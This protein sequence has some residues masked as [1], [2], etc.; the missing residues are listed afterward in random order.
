MR[1]INVNTFQFEEFNGIAVPEYG[2]LSHTWEGEEV[3]YVEMLNATPKTVLTTEKFFKIRECARLAAEVDLLDYIWVDTCCIDK[4][5]SAELQEAINSMYRW[6]QNAQ[7]CYVYLKDVKS[8]ENGSLDVDAFTTCR[9][10]SR[11]WTLQELIAPSRVEFY[12]STWVRIGS[13]E[14]L[15]E[16]ISS[17]S[18]I[19][20]TILLT[21][22]V[23]KASVAQRMSWAASRNCTRLEDTAYSL[24]GLF[25]IHMP[26][27]YGEGEKAFMRLQEEII[28]TNFDMS[29]FAWF[30][31]ETTS[32][33]SGMLAKSPKMFRHCSRI[34]KQVS[35]GLN[36]PYS[37]TNLGLYMS[38]LLKP[39]GIDP[40]WDVYAGR[41]TDISDENGLVISI[42]LKRV[43]PQSN[44]FVR[45]F[46]SLLGHWLEIRRDADAF[47]TGFFAY[48][49]FPITKE[50]P[51]SNIIVVRVQSLTGCF[52]FDDGT[53]SAPFKCTIAR[54][55]P[56]ELWE[57]GRNT[58]HVYRHSEDRISYAAIWIALPDYQVQRS[59]DKLSY[60]R[61][62]PRQLVI[63]LALDKWTGQR[64]IHLFNYLFNGVESKN[65]STVIGEIMGKRAPLVV[66][67]GD[68]DDLDFLGVHEI[69][70]SIYPEI[71]L[72]QFVLDVSLEM[73]GFCPQSPVSTP[74]HEKGG[75]QG[76]GMDID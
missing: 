74:L 66:D 31:K 39:M 53:A 67:Q 44:Q 51:P 61:P 56:G 40:E 35:A 33:Y 6:Y 4:S 5:S 36:T 34:V 59:N 16:E 69:R 63:T 27:L 55:W 22:D 23:S 65:M 30:D 75:S 76:T 26:M 8:I 72:D 48:V 14:E 25:D 46:P 21:G 62:R 7:W 29:I 45:A 3:Q 17:A 57:P 28:K 58:F 71:V 54:V 47:Q 38:I 18:G 73:S 68:R 49:N 70:A 42:F 60:I 9:W 24:M 12:S 10:I 50:H 41:L 52:M 13:K 2:I 43:S 20:K 64:R 32:S 1:L 37:L 19:P 11:G 15:V